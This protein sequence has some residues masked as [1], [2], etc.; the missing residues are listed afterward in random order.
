MF[1]SPWGR[2][3]LDMA[4]QLSNNSNFSSAIDASSDLQS[5]PG[6]YSH[7]SAIKGM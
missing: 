4:E 6:I 2:E 5:N 7:S 1:C 3:E